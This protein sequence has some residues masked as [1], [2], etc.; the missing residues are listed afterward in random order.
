MPALPASR[1]P[2]ARRS[3]KNDRPIRP[4]RDF[5]LH[6]MIAARR[7]CSNFALE[8]SI[9]LARELDKPLLV[10]EALRCDYRWASDRHHAFAL[11]GMRA[12]GDAFA[13]RSIGYLPYVEREPGEGKGLLAALARRAAVVVTDDYPCFFLPRMVAKA[14]RELDVALEAVDSNGLLPLAAT[15]APFPTA[16]AFRRHLQKT[17]APHLSALPKP[18]PLAR[19]SLRPLA[20][21]DDE[22]LRRWPAAGEAVLSGDARALAEL[23]IDHSVP[24]VDT[25]GGTPAALQALRVFLDRRL[26]D[27]AERRNDVEDSS[28]SGLSPWLHWGHLGAHDVYRAIAEREDFTPERVAKTANGR[29]DGW[30]NLPPH[31]EAFLDELVTWRELGHVF[32]RHQPRYDEYETLPDWARRSLAA[33]ARDPRE[34]VYTAE[35]LERGAT[36]DA[37]WNAAQGELLATGRMHNYLRMLWGKKVLQW[38]RAPEEAFARLVELNNRWALDGRDPNSYSGIAWCFG[39]FDRPWAPERPI[40][41]CIRYMSS[42]NTR[43]KL[44]VD[45]YI[46]KFE[47]RS[48]RA[49]QGRLL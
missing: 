36:H 8:R 34:H 33:H 27:Y 44:S 43:R 7:A 1:I 19:V 28:A 2:S 4:E 14:A 5:V 15:D 38:S 20:A 13:K 42:E 37:L 26:V 3:P 22:I 9:E 17:L 30:W 49:V 31:V 24:P 41:G 35:A 29:K 6:W 40:F 12:N 48:P 25:A 10:L 16:Y 47:P 18:D 45:A 46:E 39:R 21:L 23:P 11:Q 32:C